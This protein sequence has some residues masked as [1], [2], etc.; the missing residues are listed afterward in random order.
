[1]GRCI[2]PRLTWSEMRERPNVPQNSIKMQEQFLCRSWG[3]IDNRYGQDQQF[4]FCSPHELPIINPVGTDQQSTLRGS[5]VNISVIE[6]SIVDP[7]PPRSAIDISHCVN[8]ESSIV[9]PGR[10]GA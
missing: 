3:Q 9:D 6:L 7:P 1:M 10:E 5:T 2:G 8:C 4:T